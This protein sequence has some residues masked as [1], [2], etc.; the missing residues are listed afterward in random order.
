MGTMIILIGKG[1]E[2]CL[3][4]P[5]SLWL[6]GCACSWDWD[7]PMPPR[8]CSPPAH[9]TSQALAMAK[10]PPRRRMM[11]QGMVSSALF[12]VSRGFVSVLGAGQRE[13]TLTL[14]SRHWSLQA[15]LCGGPW[16]SPRSHDLAPASDFGALGENPHHHGMASALFRVKTVR[17]W[18]RRVSWKQAST[19][20][21]PLSLSQAFWASVTSILTQ[22]RG[23]LCNWM[24]TGRKERGRLFRREIKLWGSLACG[25]MGC[26]LCFQRW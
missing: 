4:G 24:C 26:F 23:S 12:H 10:P 22:G 15:C 9:L 14:R 1:G 6:L 16:G 5:C 17:P 21:H 2:W 3:Q 19:P 18:G 8:A 25:T 11:L 7:V 13:K 20:G